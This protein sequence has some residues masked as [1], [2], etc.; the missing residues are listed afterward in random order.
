MIII[1]DDRYIYIYNFKFENING[2]YQFI[3]E[4][5]L[6]IGRKKY[7]KNEMQGKEERFGI[8]NNDFFKHFRLELLVQR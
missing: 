4:L 6:L 1:K 3:F 2:M 5:V 7:G 8:P